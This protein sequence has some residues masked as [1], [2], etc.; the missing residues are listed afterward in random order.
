VCICI[1]ETE[2][3]AA[4]L[5]LR[6]LREIVVIVAFQEGEEGEEG[7]VNCYVLPV[8]CYVRLWL[9]QGVARANFSVSVAG[10]EHRELR[11]WAECCVQDRQ[12]CWKTVGRHI[13]DMHTRMGADRETSSDCQKNTS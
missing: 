12:V 7:E 9:S 4:S 6:E 2:T 13:L 10:I 8:C 11:S 3:A 5:A 1:A